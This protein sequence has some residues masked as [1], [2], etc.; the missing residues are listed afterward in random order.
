MVS[1]TTIKL[2]GKASYENTAS[3]TAQVGFLYS[4][5]RTY[6]LDTLVLPNSG[7]QITSATGIT[8]RGEIEGKAITTER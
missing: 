3:Q 2:S 4:N 5:G 8:D 1:T 7:W 6:D